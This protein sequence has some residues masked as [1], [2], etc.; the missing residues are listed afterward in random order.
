MIPLPTNEP[1]RWKIES[2]PLDMKHKFPKKEETK[3]APSKTKHH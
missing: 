1:S 2:I 3:K